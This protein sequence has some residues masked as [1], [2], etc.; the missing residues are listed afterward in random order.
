M[1]VGG[2]F[3]PTDDRDLE[4]PSYPKIFGLSLTPTVAGIALALAGA[5]GA[6]LL[7]ANLAQ[8]QLDR[9]QQLKTDIASKQQQLEGQGNPQQQLA[10]ARERLRTSRQLQADVLSLFASEDSLDTLLLDVNERVQA[11]N[12]GIQ[13]PTRRA[14]LSRFDFDPKASGLITDSSLGPSVNNQLERRVYN[15]AIVGS[16]PQAQSIIRNI[17]RLQPLLV[18]S[19]F[20]S[21][22]D[23][24]TQRIVLDPRGRLVPAGQPETQITTTFRLEALVPAK[25][26]TGN[27]APGGGQRPA[28]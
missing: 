2:D 25:S 24:S 23:Q 14:S 1:T 18:V 22:L 11:V 20:K 21:D 12:A 10:Q 3:I 28:Q 8:P 26:S 9:N 15:V 5:V 7:W 6:Y 13:D 27:S 17:E 4:G 19:N 16:F